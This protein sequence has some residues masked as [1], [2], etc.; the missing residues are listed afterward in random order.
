VLVYFP[1][2]LI[3]LIDRAVQMTDSD[4][5]KFIRNSVRRE[6]ANLRVA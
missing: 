1:K 5:S 6:L 4:R 2:D 3:P